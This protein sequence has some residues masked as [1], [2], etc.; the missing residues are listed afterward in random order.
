[1]TPTSDDSYLF[2][3]EVESTDSVPLAPLIDIVFL[4]IGFFMLAAQIVDDERD[5]E[6]EL[7]TVTH[8]VAADETTGDLIINV[9]AGGVVTVGGRVVTLLELPDVMAGRL[10]SALAAG[11]RPNVVIRTDR[12]ETYQTLDDVL[13][14]CEQIGIRDVVLRALPEG[15]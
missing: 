8:A 10:E 3:D 12:A 13:E 7:P 1:M 2:E 14:A 6:V 4:L 11:E 15:R 5:M 9:R